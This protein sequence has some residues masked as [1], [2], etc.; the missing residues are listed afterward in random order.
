MSPSPP[1][2]SLVVEISQVFCCYR[3][4]LQNTQGVRHPPPILICPNLI[5]ITHIVKF[6]TYILEARAQLSLQQ[7]TAVVKVSCSPR[8]FFSDFLF[9][10]QVCLNPRCFMHCACA[11][12]ELICFGLI[13]CQIAFKL[14]LCSYLASWAVQK[15]MIF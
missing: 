3:R 11:H 9:K 14:I 7:F 1:L 6:I 15:Y 12:L 2:I 13:S 5:P 8:I 4:C 10:L